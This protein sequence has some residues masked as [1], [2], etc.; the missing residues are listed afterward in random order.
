[1]ARMGKV[2]P[3][4]VRMVKTAFPVVIALMAAT[5]E[6]EPRREAVVVMVAMVPEQSRAPTTNIT[7]IIKTS[8]KVLMA[9]MAA[10]VVQPITQQGAMAEMAAVRATRVMVG[11]AATR[12][13]G[14]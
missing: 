9:E 7:G 5:E 11:M 10:T 8:A 4:M 14:V 3:L 2:I 6:M 1:M 12:D 13:M